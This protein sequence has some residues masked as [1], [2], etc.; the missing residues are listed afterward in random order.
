MGVDVSHLVLET[1]G[2]TNDQVVDECADSSESGDILAGAV[3][4][5]DVDLVLLGVREC[6]CQMAQVLCELATG[7]LDGDLAG[8][9]VDLDCEA[10]RISMSSLTVSHLAQCP[11]SAAVSAVFLQYS[12]PPLPLLARNSKQGRTY[13][14]LGFPAIP[15]SRCTSWWRRVL[16]VVRVS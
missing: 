10:G 2:D 3:V 5:L 1:L 12:I 4:K 9:D 7:S 15:G 6:D 16:V 14:P 13:R 11:P 8:L